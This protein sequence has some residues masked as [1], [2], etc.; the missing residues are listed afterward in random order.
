MKKKMGFWSKVWEALVEATCDVADPRRV[1]QKCGHPVLRGHRWK[2]VR[3]KRWGV[4]KTWVEHRDC[5]RPT[6][7]PEMYHA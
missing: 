4:V 7:N 6:E 3:R 2:Q 1:C 5:G